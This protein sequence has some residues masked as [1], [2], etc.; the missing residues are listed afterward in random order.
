MLK[1]LRDVGCE[2]PNENLLQEFLQDLRIA[3][4][5]GYTITSYGGAC[6]DFLNFICGLNITQATHREVSQ[7]LHWLHSRG[8]SSQTLAQ[9]KYALGSFFKFLERIGLIASSPTRLV[10]NRKIH[11]HLPKHHSVE[12]MNKLLAACDNVRDLA[13]L[14]TL[15]AT[16]CRRAELVGMKIEDV[17]WTDRTIRVIGKGDKQRL[18]PMTPNASKTVQRYIAERKTGPIFLCLPR[19]IHFAQ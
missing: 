8:S 2:E 16:G 3:G 10:P 15:W 9:R 5:A 11:R 13:L 1:Q 4:R 19:Q 6:K 7:W 17:N 12:E 18:V 14:S